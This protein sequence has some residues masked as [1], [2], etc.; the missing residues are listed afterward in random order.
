MHC[1]LSSLIVSCSRR[2]LQLSTTHKDQDNKI[3]HYLTVVIIGLIIVVV[4]ALAIIS[5]YDLIVY[6]ITNNVNQLCARY[7]FLVSPSCS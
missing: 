3:K 4:A 5:V 1:I 7:G 2:Y 6:D